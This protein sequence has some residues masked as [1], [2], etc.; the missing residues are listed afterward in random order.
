MFALLTAYFDKSRDQPSL[1]ITSV[2]G[3]VASFDEW[4]A[5]EERWAEGV[6]YWS[7]LEGFRKLGGFHMAQLER[8]IGKQNA[9]LCVKYF[10]N[11][12]RSS[13]LQAI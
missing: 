2:A 8:S 5:V 4:R 10:S 6:E 11:L 3:Y 12:I 13:K 7:K 1:C 9:E